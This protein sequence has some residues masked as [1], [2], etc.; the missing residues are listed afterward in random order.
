M[1]HCRLSACTALF[2][3]TPILAWSQA[4]APQPPAP[5]GTNIYFLGLPD[6]LESLKKAMPQPLAADKGYENQPFFSPDSTTVFFTADRDGK[7]T[8]IYERS[9]GGRTREVI[10]TAEREYSPTITPD[11]RGISVIRVEADGTQ[12]LWRFDRD[13]SHPKVLLPEIKPVGYHAWIDDDVLALFVLGPP[14]TLRLARVSTGAADIVATDIGRSLQR[15]PGR[16]AISFVQ[17]EADGHFVVKQLDADT[18]RITALTDAV[19]GS[20]D[21]DC[22]WMPDGTLLMSAG[23]RILAWKQ[24]TDGW[25]EVF[26]VRPHGLGNVT[27]MAVAPNGRAIAIVVNEVATP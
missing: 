25:R 19:A 11:G 12:R 23:T 27:R 18:K 4:A 5:P 24:G 9:V 1:F 13:G 22:A 17:K 15:I 21:R 7:Q 26:D 2:L 16:R 14:A 10:R 6:G 20:S 8:D 3:L